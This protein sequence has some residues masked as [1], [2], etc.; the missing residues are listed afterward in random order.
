TVRTDQSGNSYYLNRFS[1]SLNPIYI[2]LILG[3]TISSQTGGMDDLALHKFDHLGHRLWTQIIGMRASDEPGTIEID[4]QD[5]VYISMQ[6]VD[7]PNQIDTLFVG[8]TLIVPDIN[9]STGPNVGNTYWLWL[10]L[11]PE[12]KL[13]DHK[14]FSA[15]RNFPGSNAVIQIF[16]PQFDPSD[17]QYAW[18]AYRDG[19]ISM[20][21]LSIDDH[22]LPSQYNRSAG[23]FRLD[24]NDTIGWLHHVM[25]E[26][27]TGNTLPLYPGFQR[28][29]VDS[30]GNIFYIGRRVTVSFDLLDAPTI[31]ESPSGISP[32]LDLIVY[33]YNPEGRFLWHVDIG[34]KEKEHFADAVVADREY[35][36]L[37]GFFRGSTNF[38]TT[39]LNSEG[40]TDGFIAR[41][42][43]C[44]PTITAR[45]RD[46]I[47]VGDTVWLDA[48]SCKG[49][50]Y[51]WLRNGQVIPNAT[52]YSY[53]ATLGGDYQAIISYNGQADT[54]PVHTLGA[55]S[56]PDSLIVDVFP[57]VGCGGFTRLTVQN[58]GADNCRNFIWSNGDQLC[59]AN[60]FVSDTLDV[61]VIDS[62]GCRRSSPRI[63]VIV[64]TQTIRPPVI[65]LVG[66][67]LCSDT[68]SDNFDYIWVLND[69]LPIGINASCIAPTDTGTYTLIIR[70]YNPEDPTIGCITDYSEGLLYTSSMGPSSLNQSSIPAF[71]LY[72]NPSDGDFILHWQ[73]APQSL[74][75]NLQ[76]MNLQGKNIWESQQI[77]QETMHITFKGKISAGTYLLLIQN[78][79][80]LWSKRIQIK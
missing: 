55:I 23:H 41:Y 43:T 31:P 60:T 66:D 20:N 28:M 74:M 27:G 1:N 29:L 47:C 4:Y 36:Y 53:P 80:G 21:T 12:G 76:L 49:R 26:N 7:N 54:T 34:S 63:P 8:D 72:P 25:G 15:F 2:H 6:I 33:K 61:F 10:K 45:G 5:N 58:P 57:T 38:G 79:K 18:F 62:N 64:D 77:S 16:T 69:T 13:L 51:S 44:A 42:Y 35:L 32:E 46:L 50:S 67:S 24:T 3:D 70:T 78:E 39:V 56:Q 75:T 52:H 17:N 40:P 71:E 9:H 14:L 11:N 22:I 65:I 37:S 68:T 73:N 19:P 48:N 59:S 30:I